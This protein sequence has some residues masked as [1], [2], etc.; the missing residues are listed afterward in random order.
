[1]RPAG[2][3]AAGVRGR[4]GRPPLPAEPPAVA[5]RGG[6]DL[7]PLDVTDDDAMALA[8]NLVWPEHDDRRERLRAAVAVARADPPWL[9]RGDL[10]EAL[11]ALVEQAPPDGTGGGLPLRGDRLPRRRPTGAASPR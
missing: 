3:P 11:P 1:M 5:W 2:R 9:V 8:A 4:P 6:I 10:L 7:H